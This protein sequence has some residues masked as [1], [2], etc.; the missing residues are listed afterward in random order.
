MDDFVD[1]NGYI[2]DLR[3]L[4]QFGLNFDILFSKIQPM[5]LVFEKSWI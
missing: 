2:L 4:L 3:L 5:K 1:G